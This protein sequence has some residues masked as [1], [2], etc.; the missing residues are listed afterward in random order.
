M[1]TKIKY[2]L[3]IVIIIIILVSAFFVITLENQVKNT[4]ITST[5][6]ANFTNNTTTNNVLYVT[7]KNFTYSVYFKNV[8]WSQYSNSTCN[9]FNATP[10]RPIICYKVNSSINTS[11]EKL[12]LFFKNNLNTT[13]YLNT[14]S[15]ILLNLNSNNF[16][17]CGT[18]I[19]APLSN[20]NCTIISK[21][22]GIFPKMSINSNFQISYC[23]YSCNTTNL[24]SLFGTFKTIAIPLDNNTPF[25]YTYIVDLNK[26]ANSL[27]SYSGT[28]IVPVNLTLEN[29]SSL[30]SGFYIKNVTPQ[31]PLNFTGGVGK[32]IRIAIKF[33]NKSYNGNLA[34]KLVYNS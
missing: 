15:I 34:I 11:S 3:T 18:L 31:L 21:R 6:V 13:L 22:N 5:S 32:I 14:N 10:Q 20:F 1:K 25:N 2:I 12:I 4:Q 9:I 19:I 7:I 8:N 27:F 16:A 30:T 29:L 24:N 33:P 17:S 26:S 23:Y 28:F